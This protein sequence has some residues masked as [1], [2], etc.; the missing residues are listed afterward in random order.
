MKRYRVVVNETE[1]VVSVEPLE[2]GSVQSQPV[3]TAPQ[4]APEPTTSGNAAPAEV[5]K[6]AA[7]VPDASGVPVEAPLRGTILNI[8]VKEGAAV[9]E[10]DV[11]LTLEALK[12]ENEITSPADGVVAQILVKQGDSVDPGDILATLQNEA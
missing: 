4:A 12:L 1:Y 7:A 10:G 6:A 2:E 11:L 8:M 3:V 9:K 5:E